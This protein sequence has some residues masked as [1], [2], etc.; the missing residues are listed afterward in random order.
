VKTST[1]ITQLA[2]C[3]DGSLF[4]QVIVTT[5]RPEGVELPTTSVAL[6]VPPT[7][8]AGR[9]SIRVMVPGLLGE[10]FVIEA[11]MI[12]PSESLALTAALVVLPDGALRFP[13]QLG[14]TGALT[15]TTTDTVQFAV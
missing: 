11:L 15:T 9:K 6:A 5:K 4:D 12:V 1:T 14:T 3:G 2:V 10:M 8:G 13:G 7:P